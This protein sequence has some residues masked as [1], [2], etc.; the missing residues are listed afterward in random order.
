MIDK[1]LCVGVIKGGFPSG[2]QGDQPANNY[3]PKYSSYISDVLMMM[4]EDRKTNFFLRNLFCLKT[5]CNNESMNEWMNKFVGV[6]ILKIFEP[7][8]TKK[9][10]N[11]DH[12]HL[13]VGTPLAAKNLAVFILFVCVWYICVLYSGLRCVCV[14]IL[15]CCCCCLF[16]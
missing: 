8:I 7:W 3:E 9:K 13:K 12:Q 15:D 4:I 6:Y 10:K 14:S 11:I 1:C 16:P 2:L 5:M